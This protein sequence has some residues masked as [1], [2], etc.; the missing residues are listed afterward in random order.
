MLCVFI[1]PASS[2]QSCPRYGGRQ[3]LPHMIPIVHAILGDFTCSLAATWGK[4]GRSAFCRRHHTAIDT[5]TSP[6][7]QPRMHPP[8]HRL[9]FSPS[10]PYLSSSNCTASM[11]SLH[12]SLSLHVMSSLLTVC[13]HC[14]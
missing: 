4:L 10:P 11:F 9:N 3:V 14:F 7:F 8:Q 6:A 1:E 5:G 13:Y 2:L 12:G